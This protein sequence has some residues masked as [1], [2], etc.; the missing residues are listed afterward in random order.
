[1]G[2]EINNFLLSAAVAAGASANHDYTVTAGKTLLLK[3]VWAS[4]SGKMK[5]EVQIETGAGTNVFNTRFVGF[6]STANPNI[7]IPVKSVISVAA[8][9]R[10]RVIRT[11]KDNQAQDLYS[12]ISGNEI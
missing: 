7:E 11:N 2:D 5:I 9:V 3:Q 8:G 12:T 1:M 6:N 10:V 4:A